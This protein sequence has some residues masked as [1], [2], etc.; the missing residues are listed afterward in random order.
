LSQENAEIVREM[1]E[2]FNRDDFDG[3]MAGGSS[4]SVR[5]WRPL[6]SV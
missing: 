4:V 6:I 1:V 5:M 2:A 3:V